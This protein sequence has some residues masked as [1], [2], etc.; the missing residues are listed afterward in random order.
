MLCKENGPKPVCWKGIE[1]IVFRTVGDHLTLWESVLAE[2][3]QRRPEESARVARCWDDPAFFT[4]FVAFFY[5]R[6][7]RPSTPMEAYLRFIH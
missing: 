3:L 5:L 6:I 7:G 2:E 1:A 4:P